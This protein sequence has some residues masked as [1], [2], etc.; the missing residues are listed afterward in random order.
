MVPDHGTNGYAA[1]LAAI[2]SSTVDR[3]RGQ[4]HSAAIWAGGK[5]FDWVC[6]FTANDPVS[7]VCYGRCVRREPLALLPALLRCVPVR[8]GLRDL[9]ED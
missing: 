9:Q 5:V 6:L 2:A 4:P 1:T 8:D 7:G 3:Y